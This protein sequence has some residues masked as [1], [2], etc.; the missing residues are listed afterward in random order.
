MHRRGGRDAHVR[1]RRL[2][3]G[4]GPPGPDARAQRLRPLPSPCRA[5]LRTG[6][7]AGRA[8]RLARWSTFQGMTPAASSEARARLD[9]IVKAYD[10]RGIVGDGLTEQSVEA[11][12][13]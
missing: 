4:A 5:H 9:A 7:V 12:G 10:V 3:G 8:T 13:A 6:R 11:L 1:L 2:D